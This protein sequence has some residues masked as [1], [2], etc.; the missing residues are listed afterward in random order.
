MEQFSRVL[1]YLRREANIVERCRVFGLPLWQC[2]TLIFVGMGAVTIAA[3]LTFYF[4][5]SG[6]LDPFDVVWISVGIT[7]FLFIQS[8]IIVHAFE[9]IAEANRMQAE[10]F[11]I[12]SHQLRSPVTAARWALDFLT[13]DASRGIS[14]EGQKCVHVARDAIGQVGRLVT[15][16]LR[17]MRVEAGI[18]TERTESFPLNAL[19]DEV[20]V[21]AQRY[22]RATNLTIVRRMPERMLFVRA[23]R[24]QIHYAFDQL[25]DNA[26]RYSATAGTVTVTLAE[27]GERTRVT[28]EDEGEGVPEHEQ[29][30][31]FEKFFRASNAAVT[32]PSGAGLALYAAR[33]IVRSFGGDMGFRSRKGEGSAFWL[34]L[35]LIAAE[36]D[37]P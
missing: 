19:V 27:D 4:G 34:T 31:L 8:F 18:N 5:F 10:F 9:R 3:I 26:L 35:P 6:R 22:A 2:P 14:A 15:T 1:A 28:V 20:I 23:D 30:H 37:A 17:I 24:E 7:I 11:N 25:M 12:V 33:A 32:A 16:I 21:Q 36:P 29:E 13:S